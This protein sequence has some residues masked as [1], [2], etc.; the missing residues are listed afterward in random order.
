VK[1]LHLL[2]SILLLLLLCTMAH[3]ATP[4]AATG[5]TANQLV[6]H[7]A[8]NV[9]P[10][11]A[12]NQMVMRRLAG[13]IGAA[14]ESPSAVPQGGNGRCGKGHQLCDCSGKCIPIDKTCP[15]CIN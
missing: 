3:A 2:P 1:T 5:K 7:S 12:L 10:W 9:A 4:A 13:I 11:I 15:G 14:V 6:N 8:V